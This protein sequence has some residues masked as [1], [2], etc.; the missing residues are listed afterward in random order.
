MR[1]NRLST[2]ILL[3]VA[4]YGVLSVTP[5]LAQMVA[6][7]HRTAV[8]GVFRELASTWCNREASQD[9]EFEDAVFRLGQLVEQTRETRFRTLGASPEGRR[10]SELESELFQIRS[11]VQTA[12]AKTDTSLTS[13]R[14]LCHVLQRW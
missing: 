7:E 12:K 4:V 11:I 1:Q 9:V 14:G 8:R 13:Y 2:L 6:G 3:A 5:A 10:L